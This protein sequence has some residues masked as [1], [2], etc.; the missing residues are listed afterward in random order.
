M[1]ATTGHV[2]SV[3]EVDDW[4]IAEVTAHHTY[5]DDG[6]YTVEWESCCTISELQNSSDSSLR[7]F[8]VVDLSDGNRG[9]PVAAVDPIQAVQSGDDDIVDIP[10]TAL[11][12][13]G[14]EVTWR[15]AEQSEVLVTQPPGASIDEDAGRITWDTAG[16]SAGLYLFT[17]MA[18]DDTGSETQITF[19]ADLDGDPQDDPPVWTSGP[20]DGTVLTPLYGDTSFDLKAASGDGREVQILATAL[21]D[22]L[23]C[24]D[25]DN[26]ATEA[27]VACELD[28]GAAEGVWEPAQFLAQTPDGQSAPRRTYTVGLSTYAALGNSYQSGEGIGTYI[29]ETNRDG[30]ECRRSR[31]AYPHLLSSSVTG[32]PG[33]DRLRFAACC[34]RGAPKRV[35]P[36]LPRGP[37]C[38]GPHRRTTLLGVRC[39]DGA[40]LLATVH[41]PAAPAGRPGDVTAARWPRLSRWA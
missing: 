27:H 10:L 8:S 5:D 21:P 37:S 33:G 9:S 22:S 15:L 11:D 13:T 31:D 30:T 4:F 41:L 36:A 39:Q 17:A 20:P 28:H 29:A 24:E 23:E 3:N 38:R 19:I 25:V 34:G 12:P 1:A 2:L 32:I 40:D 16:L 35:R 6:P 26:P 14:G 7:S 18:A